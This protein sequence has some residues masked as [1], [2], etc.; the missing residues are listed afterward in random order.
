VIVVIA[1]LQE[2]LFLAPGEFGSSCLDQKPSEKFHRL[3][4]QKLAA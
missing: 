1:A 4:A 2:F 3:A